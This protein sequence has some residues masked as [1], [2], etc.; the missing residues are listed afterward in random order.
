[1]AD[2]R[3]DVAALL[4]PTFTKKEFTGYTK[5]KVNIYKSNKTSSKVIATLD[6]GKKVSV[7]AQST[8]WYRIKYNNENAYIK[9][10]Q[11]SSTKSG[12][13]SNYQVQVTATTGL[14]IRKEASK[15]ASKIGTL[16][17]KDKVT[18]SKTSGNWGYIASKKGWIC[19]DYA[20]KV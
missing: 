13:S 8:D 15:S 17:Y 10:S 3:K 16:K 7:I 20:K 18:I 14:N 19:L 4:S 9:K 1:M 2:V 12:E 5:E 11:I 6:K